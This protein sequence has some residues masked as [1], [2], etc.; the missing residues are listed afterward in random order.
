MQRNALPEDL[1][2]IT[3]E[4]ISDDEDNFEYERVEEDFDIEDDDEDLVE[5]L[6]SIQIK[7]GDGQTIQASNALT[8]VRPSVVD[9]FIRNFLVNAGLKRTLETFNS[10]WYELQSKG[11][12]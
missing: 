12:T 6:A 2:V 8:Q 4:E 9:D 10:E 3:Q 11:A 7:R 1:Q 5:A